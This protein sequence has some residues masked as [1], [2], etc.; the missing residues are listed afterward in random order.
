MEMEKEDLHTL[1]LMGEIDRTGDLSQ[2]ELSRRLNISLGLVNTFVKRMVNTGYF[3]ATTMPRNRVRYLLTPA[4][5][6]KK[7]RLT[8]EYL[9]YSI[10]SYK[11]I[12]RFLLNKYGEMEQNS[13]KSI[14]FYGAGEIAE[15]AYLYLQLTN[16]KLSGIIDSIDPGKQFFEYKILSPDWLFRME[17]DQILLTNIK[18]TDQDIEDLLIRGVDPERL[19]TL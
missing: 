19:S 2:R 15:M 13:V 12:K 17:W 14:L 16:I 3:K 6:A 4:G 8:I 10:D 9:R 5:L 1:R 18:D 7:S 11:E